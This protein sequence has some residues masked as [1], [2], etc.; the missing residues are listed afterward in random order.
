MG[1][2]CGEDT[3]GGGVGTRS[4]NAYIPIYNT[5]YPYIIPIYIYIYIYICIYILV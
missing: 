2:G 4:A 5:L 1:E 3:M